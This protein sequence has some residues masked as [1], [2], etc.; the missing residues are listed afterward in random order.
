MGTIVAPPWGLTHGAP[1]P[2]A[3][4]NPPSSAPTR[5][6][7]SRRRH[8][9]AAPADAQATS[10]FRARRGPTLDA[11]PRARRRRQRQRAVEPRR[12]SRRG[13]RPIDP[14]PRGNRLF[15]VPLFARAPT[16]TREALH[17]WDPPPFYF[18]LAF[19]QS[20]LNLGET[21]A[22]TS[23]RVSRLRNGDGPNDVPRL[24][25]GAKHSSTSRPRLGR[26]RIPARKSPG[27]HTLLF[28]ACSLFRG[29]LQLR[30]TGP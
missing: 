22:L 1:P 29:A 5:P 20:P 8:S 27:S 12:T 14:V 13:R 21:C 23:T 6:A 9:A 30:E 3:D 11:V 19:A 15:R 18:N 26:V 17:D 24:S 4:A 2:C 7:Q 16:S 10:A 28:I 25:G